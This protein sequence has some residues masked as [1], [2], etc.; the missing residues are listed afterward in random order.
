MSH[1][2][3]HVKAA[4]HEVG[5]AVADVSEDVG[6]V[7]HAVRDRAGTAVHE[8]R[9]TADRVVRAVEDKC[10]QAGHAARETF[11]H[12]RDRVR[13]WEND[14]EGAVRSRP[15]VSLLIAA[16][17]GCVVGMLWHRRQP[18]R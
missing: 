17:I 12:G 13:H 5:K 9:K 4:S 10:E 3:R 8:V 18:K 16:A 15:L 11:E 1:L 6:S 2:N 14:F 7:V